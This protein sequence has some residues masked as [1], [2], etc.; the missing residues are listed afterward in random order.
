MKSIIIILLKVIG[1]GIW[2]AGVVIA[3]GFWSTLFSII[4][5]LWAYYLVIE[6]LL[7][8]MGWI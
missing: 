4:I 7:Q 6:K 1:L 5:P 2:L 3:S 8:V